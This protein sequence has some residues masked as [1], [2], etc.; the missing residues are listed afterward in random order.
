MERNQRTVL[1]WVVLVASILVFAVC[2]IP[3]FR[4]FVLGQTPTFNPDIISLVSAI[5]SA[6]S[7]LLAIVFQII[8]SRDSNKSKK[9]LEEIH[10]T[11]GNITATLQKIQGISERIEWTQKEITKQI[12]VSALGSP[13]RY[14]MNQWKRDTTGTD[15]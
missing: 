9:L 8:G 4:W 6:I 15:E 10:E 5:V 11:E 1:F 14:P 3:L 12:V 2:F 13:S 7:L